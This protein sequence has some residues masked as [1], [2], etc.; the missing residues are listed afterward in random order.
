MTPTP[1]TATLSDFRTTPCHR[2]RASGT[3]CTSAH[4]HR[5]EAGATASVPSHVAISATS[6]LGDLIGDLARARI[7]G[8]QP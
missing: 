8:F 3:Q 2:T 7:G 6:R 4:T 5:R 1:A